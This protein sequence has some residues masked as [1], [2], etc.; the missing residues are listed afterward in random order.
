MKL[1]KVPN[2]TFLKE[3][4]KH[5]ETLKNEGI[6]VENYE[7]IHMSTSVKIY[8]TPVSDMEKISYGYGHPRQIQE[9]NL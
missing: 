2:S 3:L 8:F 6:V 5:L 7:F 9:K 4:T 1:I